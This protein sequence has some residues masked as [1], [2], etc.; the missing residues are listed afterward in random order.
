MTS[1]RPDAAWLLR[2]EGSDPAGT[3]TREVLCA[4]GNGYLVSRASAPEARAD[5]VHYPGTYLAGVYDRASSEV[6]GRTV[7]NE[8]LVNCPNWLP[9]TFRPSGG[10]WFTGPP[11]EETLELDMQKGLLTRRALVVD[12]LG[13]RTRLVQRRLA[14]QAQPHLLALETELTP[15]NWS[16]RMEVRS[17]LDGAVTNTGVARYR[18]LTGRHLVP[19]GTGWAPTE[20]CG[21]RSRLRAHRCAS[22]WPPG[23]GCGTRVR[24]P[25]CPA[26]TT[27]ARTRHPRPWGSTWS[28]ASR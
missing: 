11:A 17:A 25:R 16:G 20:C 21:S 10:A 1:G 19:A 14:S 8:D 22:P 28:G 4:T 15:E 23:P 5:G 2:F 24:T 6:A 3:G 13:R 18:H 12:T 9:L 7:E 27:S 26:A